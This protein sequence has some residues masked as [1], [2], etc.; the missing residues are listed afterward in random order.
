M[1]SWFDQLRTLTSESRSMTDPLSFPLSSSQ[2]TQWFQTEPT[3]NLNDFKTYVKYA[4]EENGPVFAAIQARA[5][6]LSEIEFAWQTRDGD[7]ADGPR[8]LREPWPG[9]TTGQLVTAIEVS[10]SLTGAAHVYRSR[11]TNVL[12][13]LRP[14]WL[15][16]L[17]GEAATGRKVPVGYVYW[18]G[19]INVGTPE[20]IDTD[21]LANIVPMPQGR[22]DEPVRGQSWISAVAWEVDSDR[23]MTRHKAKYFTNGATPLVAVIAKNQLTQEQRD[24]MRKVFKER[25][26]GWENAYKTLYLEGDVDVKALGAQLDQMTFSQVQGAGETRIASASGVPAVILGFAEGLQ[27]ATYSNYQQAMRRFADLTCRPLWRAMCDGLAQIVTPTTRNSSNRLWYDDSRVSFLQQDAKD[28]AD[29]QKAHA[30]TLRMLIDAGFEP[31]SAVDAVYTADFRKLQHSGLVSVQ[32]L[33]PGE[34][35]PQSDDDSPNDGD[36]SDA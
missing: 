14:D 4:Y 28:N 12:E 9:G 11:G 24:L 23:L 33:P 19:G 36:T 35:E 13:V 10:V 34:N 27:A 1:A 3:R 6:A 30:S 18:R 8:I 15:Q 7:L 32:L 22:L 2:L 26:E 31:D 17:Y 5:L 25:Y 29:I 20:R 21:E 16:T